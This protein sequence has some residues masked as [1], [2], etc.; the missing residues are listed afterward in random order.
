MAAGDK[1]RERILETAEQLLRKFGPEK[2]RI[3]DVASALEMSHGNIYRYFANRQAL[4]DAIAERWLRKVST[5]LRAILASKQPAVSRLDQWLITL[6]RL[7]HRRVKDDPELFQTYHRIAE[8]S[9]DVVSRHVSE[10]TD[11]LFEIIQSGAEAREW[12]VKNYRAAAEL[13]LRSTASF[14]H[15]L[16]VHEYDQRTAERK[17]RETVKVLVAGF[18]SGAI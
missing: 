10:L 2:L 1:S 3:V 8:A 13:V 15:P 9:R 16:L 11:Q 5:P 6:V 18:K 12:S 14:H 7:K 17:T 4:L